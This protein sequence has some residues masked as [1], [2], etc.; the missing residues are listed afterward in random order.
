MT[1]C[2]HGEVRGV[3]YCA[4][5]RAAGVSGEGHTDRPTPYLGSVLDWE[6]AAKHLI[7][8]LARSGQPFTSEDITAEI[9]FPDQFNQ[10]NGRNNRIGTLLNSVAKS[11]GLRR[12]DMR[13]AKNPQAHG[14]L[15]TVWIGRTR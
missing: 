14:R 12:V 13:A 6:R 5:C 7:W 8:Q 15:L 1:E 4:L 10:P 2:E 3:R 9:G 11:Y